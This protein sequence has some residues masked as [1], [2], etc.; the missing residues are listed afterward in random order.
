MFHARAIVGPPRTSAARS[1][2]WTVAR[3]TQAAIWIL[4]PVV[5]MTGFA[6]PARALDIGYAFT[7]QGFINDNGTAPT[8]PY[9]LR[10]GLYNAASG[11]TQFGMTLTLNDVPVSAGVFAVELDFGQDPLTLAELHWLQVEIRPGAS[12]GTYTLLP[13]NKLSPAPFATALSLPHRQIYTSAGALFSLTNTATGG[14]ATA[15][16][17]N[18]SGMYGLVGRTTSTTSQAAGVRGEGTGTTGLT[19]GV[20][21]LAT[22]SPNGTGLVGTGSATGAYLTAT[23]PAGSTGAYAYGYTLGLLAE[24]LGVGSAILAKGKGKTRSDAVIRVENSETDRGMCAFFQ[25]NSNYATA[26]LQNSGT[27]EV[28]YIEHLGTGDFIRVVSP[29]GSKFWVD[30]NGTTHTKVLEILGGADLSERF[31][32]AG[33]GHELVPGSVVSIDATH[34]G[35]LIVSREPYDHRVAG[36]VSGAGGITTGMLMGQKGAAADGEQPVALSG[37]VYCLATAANG[38]IRP[39]D[40]LTTSSTPGHAMRVSDSSRAHGATLGKAM[41]T[42]ESGQGLVLVLV[43]LQ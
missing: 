33:S 24:N 9:D 1:G 32:V 39:G 27:G 14:A 13:R 35:R 10:F 20:Q 17:F 4:I 7:Y 42:L 22:A 41:G 11:G 43:S 30:N 36:I 16:E 19:I 29:T 21:G 3:L 5:L 34:E 15:G 25:N 28:L 26:H 2:R 6:S 31:D 37:R 18:S 23:N 8:G 40:L 12:T 38:P